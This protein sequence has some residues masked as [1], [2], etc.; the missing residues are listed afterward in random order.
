MQPATVVLTDDAGFTEADHPRG[1]SKNAGQF[2][3]TA[4]SSS[5]ESKPP[6]DPAGA[7]KQSEGKVGGGESKIAPEEAQLEGAKALTGYLK[8]IADIQQRPGS[9]S[10]PEFILQHGKS[11]VANEKTYEGPR[12]PMKQCYKNATLQAISN[13]DLAY[14]EGYVSV[15]GV[16]IEHAWNVDKTGQIY[17]TTIN[18][19]LGVSGYFGV[20][21]SRDYVEKSALKNK[22]YGLLGYHSRKSLE[23]LLKGETKNFKA[24]EN[25][26]DTAE[27]I[28]AVE[29]QTVKDV[30]KIQEEPKESETA[31]DHKRVVTWDR[32]ADLEYYTTEELGP[33]REHTPEGFLI[34]YDVPVARTGEMIYGPDETPI[35][36]GSDGRVRITRSEAEVFA[37]KSLASL[38]GKPVTD[39]HPP[40]DVAPDNWRFY[41]RGFVQNPRRGE[42]EHKNFVVVDMVI[43]D[44]EMISDI[45]AGKNQ[46]SA[47]YNPD[48]LE[49]LDD[50][51]DVIPGVGEQANILFNHIAI[52]DSARCGPRCSIRDHKTIDSHTITSSPDFW[53]YRRFKRLKRLAQLYS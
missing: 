20:P 40:V 11:Y 2:S 28:K 30:P 5:S 36:V 41:T 29:A 46:V 32:S 39:D 19:D 27:F 44:A 50:N 51:G 12:D 16:P 42:G 47:G 38:Q 33:N 35:K 22:Y 7:V 14:V 23:P 13:E 52:V 48:Y 34:C 18:P 3:K 10:T 53:S 25:S 4:G 43:Y 9:V 37:P 26:M 6:K 17:D 49:V 21:F 45:I 24:D 8:Q 31:K 15:H 1:N